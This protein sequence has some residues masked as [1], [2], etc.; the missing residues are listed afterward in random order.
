MLTVCRNFR[1]R[2]HGSTPAC[3]PEGPRNVRRMSTDAYKC[4]RMPTRTGGDRSR[5]CDARRGPFG[6]ASFS[7]SV[8]GARH[9][10]ARDDHPHRRQHARA[11]LDAV[12]IRSWLIS[13]CFPTLNEKIGGTAKLRGPLQKALFIAL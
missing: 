1:P 8:P 11:L 12:E 13:Y 4:L 2:M 9:G 5:T 7:N 10:Q 6:R 3:A